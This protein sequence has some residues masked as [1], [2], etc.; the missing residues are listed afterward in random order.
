MK[1]RSTI[2]RLH[3][4]LG[5]AQQDMS[6]SLSLI[7]QM[8]GR[9]SGFDGGKSAKKTVSRIGGA[10]RIDLAGVK[11]RAREGGLLQ[12]KAEI[13]RGRKAGLTAFPL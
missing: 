12:F 11:S 8:G 3:P 7:H 1:K 10:E 6:D 13:Q 5:S 9:H 2:S 4:L